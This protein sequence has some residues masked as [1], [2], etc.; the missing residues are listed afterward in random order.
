[1][2]SLG[3]DE[4]S[5]EDYIKPAAK[6]KK[7][8]QAPVTDFFDNTPSG[9]AET[10]KPAAKQPSGSKL[11]PAKKAVKMDSDD[12]V[13]IKSDSDAPPSPRVV[14]PKRAVRAKI[15]KYIEVESGSEMDD[16]SMFEDD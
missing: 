3:G 1:L 13:S 5:E 15:K 4:D 14:A 11:V 2:F 7:L 6:K 12:E 16:V 8:T 10:K 9:P